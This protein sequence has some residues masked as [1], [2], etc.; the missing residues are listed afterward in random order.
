MRKEKGRGYQGGMSK[1]GY[2]VSIVCLLAGFA[3]GYLCRGSAGT[4]QVSAASST[5]AEQSAVEKGMA[6]HG[7]MKQDLSPEK[8]KSLADKQAAP[9]IEQLKSHP[10]D[11]EL[12]TRIGD[13]YFDAQAFPTAIEY[14]QKSLAANDKNN[15]ARTDMATALFNSNQINRAISEI[16]RVLHDDPKN[17]AA[18]FN[19]GVMKWQG[20]MDAKG[21]ISDWETILQRNPNYEQADRVRKFIARAKK[22]IEKP[23]QM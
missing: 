14:F 3:C 11:A 10:N 17:D 13:L 19:R 2:I 20:K 6:M 18:L 5:P 7:G 23:T 16:N 9:M 8:M 22:P 4:A 1:Q 12:A 15:G 21:A